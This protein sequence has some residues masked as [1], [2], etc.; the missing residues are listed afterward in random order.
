MRPCEQLRAAAAEPWEAMQA[1]RFV[2][3]IEAD[4]LPSGVFARY[5]GYERAFVETAIVIFGHALLRAPGL[6]QRRRLCGILQGLAGP[7]LDYFDRS[8][9]ALGLPPSPLALPSPVTRFCDGTRTIAEAGSY[10]TIMAMML[11]AEWT[12]ATWCLRANARPPQDKLLADWL[13]LHT[14]ADFLDQVAWL[15]SEVD[16]I[17]TADP[18]GLAAAQDTFAAMLALEIDFHSAAFDGVTG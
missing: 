5:L 16:A 1:H 18:A 2:R 15:Q 4:Q 11:A 12:Y 10:A 13:R 14:E 8:L 17:L 3:D 9:A 6:T 7:Q